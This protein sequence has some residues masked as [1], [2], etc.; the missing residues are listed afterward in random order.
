VFIHI[1][2]KVDKLYSIK[3]EI[4]SELETSKLIKQFVEVKARR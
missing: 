4:A 3:H 2:G 1:L